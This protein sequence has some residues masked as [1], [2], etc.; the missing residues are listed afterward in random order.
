MGL[1]I[2]LQEKPQLTSSAKT[3]F[4]IMVVLT[5]KKK[6]FVEVLN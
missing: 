4:W 1:D 3:N 5:M 2:V 6:I